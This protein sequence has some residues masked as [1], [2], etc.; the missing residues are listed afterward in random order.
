MIQLEG[1]S[2]IDRIDM[3]NRKRGLLICFPY[4]VNPVNP[5]YLFLKLSHYLVLLSRK[6][7]RFFGQKIID[8]SLS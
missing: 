5:V 2:E 3:I 1:K 8:Y 4:L 7:R 6:T